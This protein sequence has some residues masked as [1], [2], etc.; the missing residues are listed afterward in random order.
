MRRKHRPTEI[1]GRLEFTNEGA[2]KHVSLRRGTNNASDPGH[3]DVCYHSH[4]DH[5]LPSPPSATDLMSAYITPAR[6]HVLLAREGIYVF[7]CVRTTPLGRELAK[8][9]SLRYTRQHWISEHVRMA[10]VNSVEAKRGGGRK[11]TLAS[12]RGAPRSTKPE[13]IKGRTNNVLERS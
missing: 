12:S 8:H 6:I 11:A 2:L 7:R 10:V 13:A 5:Q 9:H 4:P 1:A 3:C